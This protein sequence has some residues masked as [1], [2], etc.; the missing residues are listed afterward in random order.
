M[1]DL[2]H[3]MLNLSDDDLPAF[4]AMRAMIE[5]LDDR[6]EERPTRISRDLQTLDADEAVRRVAQ[7]LISILQDERSIDYLIAA[8]RA[9][10]TRYQAA[11]LLGWFGPRAQ[12]A[13]PILVEIISW[14]TAATGAA[15]TAVVQIGGGSDATL[16]A[17][18]AMLRD[19][20]DAGYVQLLSLAQQMG[21][22]TS[23]AFLHLL[24]SASQSQNADIREYTADAIGDLPVQL[25]HKVRD[26]IERLTHD[27]QQRVRDAIIFALQDKPAPNQRSVA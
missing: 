24:D 17:L 11:V 10:T 2:V 1:S 13:V 16:T 3:A 4:R 26:A 5:Q 23:S 6:G 15:T 21:I 7:R 9:R 22:A 25:R 19:A 18:H 27:Q 20:D 12:R 14:A 8:L